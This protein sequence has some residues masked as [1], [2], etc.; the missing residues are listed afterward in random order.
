[1]SHSDLGIDSQPTT[2]YICSLTG[3]W[4][5][6]IANSVSANSTYTPSKSL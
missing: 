1:M 6:S 4:F 5:A 2:P 3:V